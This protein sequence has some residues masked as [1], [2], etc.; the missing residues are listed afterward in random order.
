MRVVVS[1]MYS[2][3]AIVGPENRTAVHAGLGAVGAVI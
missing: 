2:S 1:Y 3:K